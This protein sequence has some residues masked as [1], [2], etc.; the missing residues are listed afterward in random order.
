MKKFILFLCLGLMSLTSFSQQY[1]DLFK[2]SYQ[3]NVISACEDGKGGYVHFYEME[4]MGSSRSTIL[5]FE[6]KS[7][8]DSL[9]DDFYEVIDLTKKMLKRKYVEKRKETPDTTLVNFTTNMKC[10]FLLKGV[11]YFDR[12]VNLSYELTRKPWGM[13]IKVETDRLCDDENPN[14]CVQGGRFVFLDHKDFYLFPLYYLDWDDVNRILNEKK[15]LGEYFIN[16]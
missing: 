14:I 15:S 8:D 1:I 5:F 10:A 6:N 4:P 13:E 7:E 12:D 3:L 16:Q 9:S 2:S 11:W